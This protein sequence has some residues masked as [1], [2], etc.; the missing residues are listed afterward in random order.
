MR[1][2]TPADTGVVRAALER[3][4]G[5]TLVVARGEA[6]DASSL[7]AF[8]AWRGTESVGL[9]T[10]RPGPR[11]DEWE[12]VSIAAFVE[13]AG[14]GTALLA[15]VR[16]LARGQAIRRLWLVTTNDNTRAIRFYQ[17]RGFDLVAL[18]R[19]AVTAGRA[20]KPSI[21]WELD[22]IPLRHELEFDIVP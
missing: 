4:W 12:I 15:A 20:L 16:A 3:S 2:A 19:D 10:H 14:V 18:H 8:V 11:P 6:I 22:G 21:P 13:G 17:R 9:L 5:G 7:A 1:E